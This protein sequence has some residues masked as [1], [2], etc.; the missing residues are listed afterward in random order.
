MIIGEIIRNIKY[1]V[2]GCCGRKSILGKL[3][4]G[5]SDSSGSTL[6]TMGIVLLIVAVV[7]IIGLAVLTYAGRVSNAIGSTYFPW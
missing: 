1:M 3:E 5:D 6:R 7:T 2:Q 4:H